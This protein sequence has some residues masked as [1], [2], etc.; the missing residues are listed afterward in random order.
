MIMSTATKTMIM[1]TA[2]VTM[3]MN[4]VMRIMTMTMNTVMRIMTTSMIMKDITTIITAGIWEIS[5]G[6]W[7][8]ES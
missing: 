7:K 2:M 8:R 1:R 5:S 6:F 4:T 3:T